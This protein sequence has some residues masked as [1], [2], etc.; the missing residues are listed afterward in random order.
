MLLS[1]LLSAEHLHV[2]VSVADIC[3]EISYIARQLP[4]RISVE[5]TR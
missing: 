1:V 5:H 3:F 4:R 2:Q